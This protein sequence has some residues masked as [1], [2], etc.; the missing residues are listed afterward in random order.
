MSVDQQNV[1]KTS[2]AWLLKV[3]DSVSVAVGEF[4]VAECV[5]G[6]SLT[7]IPGAVDYCNELLYFRGN[8]VPVIDFSKLTNDVALSS[9]HIVV[10][11]YLNPDL[12]R[13]EYLAIKLLHAISRI[14][15]PDSSQCDWPQNYPKLLEP[16]VLSLF[17]QNNT[18][19]SIVNL[20]DICNEGYSDFVAAMQA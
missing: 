20:A 17:D 13:S 15:V 9:Q 10:V 11:A 14:D 8:F 1:T 2:R 7:T 5:L 12:Q 6:E 16:I 3:T 4:S 18:V 19:V